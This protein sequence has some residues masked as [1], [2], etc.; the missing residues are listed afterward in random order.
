MRHLTLLV[1]LAACGSSDVESPDG[2]PPQPDA[3]PNCAA[4][5]DVDWQFGLAFASITGHVDLPFPSTGRGSL[6]F[7]LAE[8]GQPDARTVFDVPRG[9]TCIGYTIRG[10]DAGSYQVDLLI[11]HDHDQ[12]FGDGDLAGY[13]GGTVAAPAII[14]GI[15]TVTLGTTDQATADFGVGLFAC[16]GSYGDGCA[17]DADCRG[18]VTTCSD[19]TASRQTSGACQGTCVELAAADCGAA[20]VVSTAL[21]SCYGPL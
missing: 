14:T 2:P 12:R 18:T 21:G 5:P 13:Y 7:S 3:D 6:G 11:D 19:G 10:L 1:F 17:G 16:A 4:Q 20:T 15:G 8:P 9:R